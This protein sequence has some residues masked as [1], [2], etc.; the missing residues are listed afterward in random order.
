MSLKDKAEMLTAYTKAPRV[1]YIVRLV[2]FPS[3]EEIA[4]TILMCLGMLKN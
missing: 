1:S 4:Y 2:T 3:T